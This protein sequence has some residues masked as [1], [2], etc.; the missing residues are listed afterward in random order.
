MEAIYNDRP[1]KEI[2]AILDAHPNLAKEPIYEDFYATHFAA[3]RGRND[4][5]RLLFDRGATVDQRGGPRQATPLVSAIQED[6]P[7]TVILLL[8]AGADPYASMTDGTTPM[9]FA[10]RNASQEVKQVL[11]S[12]ELLGP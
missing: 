1:M 6:Q 4:V 11:R 2:E 3:L 7:L 10:K 5:L 8:D 9:E 12:R